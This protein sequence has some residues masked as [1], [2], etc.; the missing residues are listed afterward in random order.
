MAKKK[1][2]PAKKVKVLAIERIDPERHKVELEIVGPLPELPATVL[3]VEVE[4]GPG[5]QLIHEAK[6]WVAWLKNL[7]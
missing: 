2:A 3:P 6:L 7:W 1:K 4:V 5:R